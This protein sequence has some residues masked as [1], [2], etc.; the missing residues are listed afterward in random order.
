MVL[1][2]FHGDEREEWDVLGI[3]DMPQSSAMIPAF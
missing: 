1:L 3:K 2:F